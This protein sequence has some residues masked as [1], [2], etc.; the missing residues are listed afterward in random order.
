MKTIEIT[1][2]NQ[3]A[4]FTTKSMTFHGREFFYA[5]MTDVVNHT[6]I[7]TYTFIYDGVPKAFP[8]E[9]K[10]AKVLNAIFSQVQGMQAEKGKPAS[11]GQKPASQP[12][13]AASQKEQDA[14]KPAAMPEEKT[15]ERK[16]QTA[17]FT[18][19]KTAGQGTQPASEKSKSDSQTKKQTPDA[20]SKKDDETSKTPGE[21]GEK[22]TEKS[23]VKGFFAA[24][25]KKK[26]EKKDVPSEGIDV[27]PGRQEKLKKSFTVF[28]II[29]AVVIVLSLIYYF[30]FGTSNDPT[31]AN[32][33]ATESQQ[34]N[35]IDELIDDLQ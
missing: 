18:N 21:T 20:A 28:G 1:S 11:G 3:K 4:L 23:S 31:P 9:E 34:Y 2:G 19:E 7:H 16:A 8:Y 32:P 15:A 6:D 33:N 35:D 30:V 17:G 14:S 22:D 29:I 13:S 24:A 25:K 12:G 27:D 10:D 5:N 26:G